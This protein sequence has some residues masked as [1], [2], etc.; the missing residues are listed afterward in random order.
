MGRVDDQIA[1]LRATD[2]RRVVYGEVGLIIGDVTVGGVDGESSR[3]PRWEVDPLHEVIDRHIGYDT[4]KEDVLF[5]YLSTDSWRKDSNLLTYD[6]E[7][8]HQ[9]P[10]HHHRHLFN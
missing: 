4:A 10:H 8:Y 6:Q 9:P 1:G 2:Q 5:P 7:K 3:L